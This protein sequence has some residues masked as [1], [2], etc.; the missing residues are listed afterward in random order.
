MG[1][2]VTEESGVSNVQHQQRFQSGKALAEWKSLEQVENGSPS[3]SPPSLDSD[4][5]DDDGGPNPSDLYGK[6]TWTI[7]KF[8][9]SNKRVIRSNE[10]EVGGYRWYI[11]IYPQGCDVYNHLSLFLCAVNLDELLP[12]WSHFAQF[13]IAVVNK[14]PKRSTYFVIREKSN[15]PFRCLDC[16]YRRELVRVYLT[17]VELICRRFV[18]ERRGKL[19]KLIQDKARWASF[20]AFWTGMEQSSRHRMSREKTEPILKAVVKYFFIEKEVTST[21]V[22]DALYNGLKALESQ[23]KGKKSKGKC[24]EA[25]ELPVPIVRIEKDAFA[26]VDNVSL[27]L[28]RAAME[29]LLPKDEKA[30]QNR[31]VDPNAGEELNNDSIERDERRLTELGRWTIEIFV[32][33]HIFS[34]KIE[35]AYREALALKKQEELIREE[36]TWR[37]GLEQKTRRGATGKEK[38]SQKKSVLLR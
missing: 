15:W 1:G 35:V 31:T 25:E 18:E 34:S 14:D 36:A 5:D 6:Y 10:F 13:T 30:L 17:N 33:D 20:C 21:L 38:K 28:E 32:F 3:T 11:L 9:Q 24:L 4:N 16:R 26:L 37:A 2:D 29:P 8:S 7:D 22:M 27:F 12:G 19:E 23:N